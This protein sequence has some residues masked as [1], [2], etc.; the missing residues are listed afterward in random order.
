[1][2]TLN[3][4]PRAERWRRISSTMAVIG[5]LRLASRRPTSA[6][7]TAIGNSPT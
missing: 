7:Q 3:E 5:W 2:M 6:T 1:M 4:L